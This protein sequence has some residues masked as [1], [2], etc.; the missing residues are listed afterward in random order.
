MSDI[1]PPA[2]PP[3]PALDDVRLGD[4]G[5]QPE[6]VESPGAVD[7]DAKPSGGVPES[8]AS[9]SPSEGRLRR[10]A[11]VEAIHGSTETPTGVAYG[12]E[13]DGPAVAE[14]LAEQPVPG[15]YTVEV[16]GR[17]DAVSI[18][19]TVLS[20]EQFAQVVNA[21]PNYRGGPVLLHAANTG[22]GTHPFAQSLADELGA[23]VTAPD[24]AGRW[25]Y[26]EPRP[27]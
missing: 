5:A 2:P 27:S 22:E 19:D 18:D 25:R 1:P 12:T 17:S 10:V 24:A 23:S 26:F 11:L 3:E 6:V 9:E 8:T 14:A 20:P 15:L 13:P 4:A 21:H 7:L 16:C